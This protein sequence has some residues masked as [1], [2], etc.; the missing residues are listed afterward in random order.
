MRKTLFCVLASVVLG[1]GIAQAHAGE[2]HHR[3]DHDRRFRLACQFQ[4]IAPAGKGGASIHACSVLARVCRDRNE[5]EWDGLKTMADIPT[6]GAPGTSG[7]STPA[8]GAGD[9]GRDHDHHRDRRIC[10]DRLLVTCDDRVIYADGAIKTH[11][12]GYEFLSGI[13]G[14]PVLKFPHDR[15][16]RR[17]DDRRDDDRREDRERRSFVVPSWLKVGAVELGG[18]C[19]ATRLR[20][21]FDRDFDDMK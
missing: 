9:D 18:I 11:F 10:R 15:F 8:V 1:V 17:F 2:D 13:V 12:L 6:P 20:D 3:E 5:D 4:G 7:P 21:H 16:E 19:E 14:N